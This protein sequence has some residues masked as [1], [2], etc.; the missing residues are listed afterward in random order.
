MHTNKRSDT[1]YFWLSSVRPSFPN[2]FSELIGGKPATTSGAFAFARNTDR[3]DFGSF[4]DTDWSPVDQNRFTCLTG[5]SRG[6]QE[7][8]IWQSFARSCVYQRPGRTTLHQQKFHDVGKY[9][10]ARERSSR[11]T[12]QVHGDKLCILVLCQYL[13]TN[14]VMIYTYVFERERNLY[15]ILVTSNFNHEIFD[16]FSGLI[17]P[18]Q[19]FREGTSCR[20]GV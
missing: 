9:W 19:I 8:C 10:L 16:W 4:P 1:R 3:L 20:K 15:F 2:S 17:F 7:R 13:T 6:S 5:F 14:C 12:N 18:W 11:R